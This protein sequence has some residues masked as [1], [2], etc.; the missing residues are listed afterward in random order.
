MSLL[1]D[2]AVCACVC[3]ARVFGCENTEGD[4]SKRSDQHPCTERAVMVCSGEE[5]VNVTQ[6]Y[7]ID[8]Q[9]ARR[10]ACYSSE[11]DTYSALSLGI[12]LR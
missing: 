12:G 10:H 5:A 2:P 4:K 8:G 6:S 3:A 9:I 1:A 7:I 11:L